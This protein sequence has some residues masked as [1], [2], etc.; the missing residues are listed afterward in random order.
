MKHDSCKYGHC[1]ISPAIQISFLHYNDVI[2]STMVF[3]ITGIWIVYSIVCSCADQR[4]HQSS[5]SLVFVRNSP[6]KGPVTRKMFPFDDVDMVQIFKVLSE[7]IPSVY[8]YDSGRSK[9]T[10]QTNKSACQI[11][12]L[13]PEP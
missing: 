11:N 3:Q 5:A 6:Q 1:N 7:L 4:K 9:S 12:L 10:M 8:A 2:M 13:S